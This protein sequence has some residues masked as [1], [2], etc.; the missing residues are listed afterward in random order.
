MANSSG[1]VDGGIAACLR[2]Q[3]QALDGLLDWE[4]AG[5]AKLLMQGCGGQSTPGCCEWVPAAAVLHWAAV[6]GSSMMSAMLCLPMGAKSAFA[7]VG[8]SAIKDL[9]NCR[10]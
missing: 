6:W 4:L 7:L 3:A 5:W 9:A 10:R 2:W 8:T 1:A